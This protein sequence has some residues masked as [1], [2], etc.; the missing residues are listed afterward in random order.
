MAVME[1]VDSIC[2]PMTEESWRIRVQSRDLAAIRDSLL[3]V[4][5]AGSPGME[6]VIESGVGR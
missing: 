5:L 6:T 2:G 3:P 4:L 1:A